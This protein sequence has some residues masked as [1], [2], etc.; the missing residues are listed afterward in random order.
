MRCA[1]PSSGRA[2][3][4]GR[5]EATSTGVASGTL[6]PARSVSHSKLHKGRYFPSGSIFDQYGARDVDQRREVN[7][8]IPVEAATWTAPTN[9]ITGGAKTRAE[10]WGRV[11]GLTVTTSG[12]ELRSCAG[13]LCHG[14][15]PTGGQVAAPRWWPLKVPTLL[16][17]LLDH[18]HRP[19]PQSGLIFFGMA[20]SFLTQK[21]MGTKVALRI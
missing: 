2:V 18:P 13:C 4:I 10:W 17:M 3:R 1:A 14:R 21:R 19:S 6:G 9:S 20:S 11:R 16:L 5:V 8:A 7:P 12:Y 15:V